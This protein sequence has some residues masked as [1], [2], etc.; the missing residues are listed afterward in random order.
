MIKKTFEKYINIHFNKFVMNH[1]IVDFEGDFSIF[2]TF[3]K[4]L[5]NR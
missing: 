3:F 1:E 2:R 4:H 5:R